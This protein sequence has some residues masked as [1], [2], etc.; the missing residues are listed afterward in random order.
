MWASEHW[1]FYVYD[2]RFTLVTDHQALKTLLTA[3]S[4]GRRPPRLHRSANRLFQYTFSV[5]YRPG[6]QNVVANCLSRAFK[7]SVSPSVVP[8][9]HPRN[10]VE[11]DDDIVIQTIFGNLARSVVTLDMVAAATSADPDLQR[12]LQH[13]LHGWPSSKSEVASALRTY[14]NVQAELSLAGP[15]E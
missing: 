7:S 2:R 3:G 4:T 13:V 1:K 11:Y 8:F 6:K 9:G 12:L 5:V 15:L 10:D 14:F